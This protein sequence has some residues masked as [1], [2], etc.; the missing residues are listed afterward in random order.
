MDRT[1]RMQAILSRESKTS[2]IERKDLRDRMNTAVGYGL[3]IHF[4]AVT[5]D[6]T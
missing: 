1:H 5:T 3:E 4:A 6:M 2:K